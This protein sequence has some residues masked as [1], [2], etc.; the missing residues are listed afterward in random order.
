MSFE[1]KVVNVRTTELAGG[2]DREDAPTSRG[3]NDA[4]LL[5]KMKQ[6]G[7]FFWGKVKERAF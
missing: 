3:R 4:T 6:Y 1:L 5:V 2:T 7:L